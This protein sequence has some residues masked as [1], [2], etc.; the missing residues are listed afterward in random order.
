MRLL[1]FTSWLLYHSYLDKRVLVLRRVLALVSALQQLVPLDAA[2]LHPVTHQQL[3]AP[4]VAA[5]LRLHLLPY[6]LNIQLLATLY[7]AVSRQPVHYRVPL[8]QLL[9]QTVILVV[10]PLQVACHQHQLKGRLLYYLLIAVL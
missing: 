3:F 10:L 4:L 7:Q 2:T 5:V 1:L 8:L 6:L 9:V